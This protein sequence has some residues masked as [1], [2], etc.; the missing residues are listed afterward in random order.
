MGGAARHLLDFHSG[1]R[2]NRHF[3]AESSV[4]ASCLIAASIALQSPQCLDPEL[5]IIGVAR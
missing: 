4:F 3:I 2:P 5:E 1:P